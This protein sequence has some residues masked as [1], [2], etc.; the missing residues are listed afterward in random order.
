M[1]LLIALFVVIPLCIVGCSTCCML[2]QALNRPS[3]TLGTMSVAA[4]KCAIKVID[5]LVLLWVKLSRALAALKALPSCE[6][7]WSS[8]KIPLRLKN[9]FLHIFFH[10]C[11]FSSKFRVQL[12]VLVLQIF[13]F[14]ISNLHLIL[15]VIELLLH[16]LEVLQHLLL[17]W[18]FQS[19]PLASLASSLAISI[20]KLVM[21]R[22]QLR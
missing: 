8:Y 11:A 12:F 20:F 4:T 18:C 19:R 9:F 21:I 7:A 5:H 16:A 6:S 3:S 2:G 13:D 1:A 10:I 15:E 14:L 17:R 22:Y